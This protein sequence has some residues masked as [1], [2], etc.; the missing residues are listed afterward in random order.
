M[1]KRHPTGG[2]SVT[3]QQFRE[4]ANINSIVRT[5]MRTGVVPAHNKPPIF[6][7]VPSISYHE[8]LNSITNVDQAFSSLKAS[9][10]NRFRNAGN[11]LMFI[12]NPANREEAIKLGLIDEPQK[13]Q[14]IKKEVVTPPAPITP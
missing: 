11:L 14:E 2:P 1:S 10:R 6:M 7:E 9:L 5:I 3:Q 12:E 4:Q 13:P 8:M